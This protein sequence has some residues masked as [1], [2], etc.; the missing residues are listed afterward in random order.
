VIDVP[1]GNGR[2]AFGRLL[3]EPLV[4]FYDREFDDGAPNLDE[5]VRLPVAFT[6]DVMNSAVTSG[7]WR[8]AGSKPL[9]EAERERIVRFCKRDLMTGE[10]SLY[11]E[12][13]RSGEI[14]EPPASPEDCE[15]LETAAV[16]SAEHVEDRLRDHFAGRPNKWL[17]SIRVA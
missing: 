15:G 10:P 1:L 7:R 11:W 12:D 5:I 3:S 8:K 9:T 4:E 14:H 2:H 6:I 13:P 17:E 16:W